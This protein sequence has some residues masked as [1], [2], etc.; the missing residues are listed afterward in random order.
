MR[1][2]KRIAAVILVLIGIILPGEYLQAKTLFGV[3]TKV[4]S[5]T[6]AVLSWKKQKVSGYEVYKAAVSDTGELGKYKKIGTISKNVTRLEVDTAYGN[7]DHYVIKGYDIKDGKKV[8]DLRGESD[9]Y[10]GMGDTYWEEYYPVAAT[11]TTESISLIFGAER[12]FCPDGFEIYRKTKGTEFEKIK[13]LK[14]TEKKMGMEYLDKD[15]EAG[16]TYAYRVR[17]YKTIGGKKLY[18]KYTRTIE[19]SAVNERGKYKVESITKDSDYVSA[20]A[21]A[22]TSDENNGMT[23]FYKSYEWIAYL[24]NDSNKK[25]GAGEIIPV[26]YSFDRREWFVLREEE[27]ERVFVKPGETIYLI[28]AVQSVCQEKPGYTIFNK[29][30][31][32]V[33]FNLAEMQKAGIQYSDIRYNSFRSFLDMDL[34]NKTAETHVNA[35]YYH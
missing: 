10:S 2:A 14:N 12:G 8:Y 26:S 32:F 24:Y 34:V 30:E 15:V 4:I 9:V 25:F 23:E 3:E 7:L 28:F 31:K 6:K 35:E 18:G 33:N 22:I 21:L 13:T 20:F 11:I 29:D 1:I 17:S 27:E 5:E 19:L 16:V